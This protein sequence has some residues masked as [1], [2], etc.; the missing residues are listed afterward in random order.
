MQYGPVRFVVPLLQKSKSQKFLVGYFKGTI[1]IIIIDK[2]QDQPFLQL[3]LEA[4][5]ELTC[6]ACNPGGHNVCIGTTFG[7]MFIISLTSRNGNQADRKY[8]KI[9]RISNTTENAVTSIQMTTF[10]P[11]GSLLVAFDNGQ[12]RVWQSVLSEEQR[13]KIE[14]YYKARLQLQDD[15]GKK[16]TKKDLRKSRV[17]IDIAQVQGMKFDVIDKFDMFENPHN[18]EEVTEEQAA[19]YRELYGVSPQYLDLIACFRARNTWTARP[20]SSRAS[21]L[22]CMCVT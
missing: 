16:A 8:V 3:P 2:L 12:V 18:L 20:S 11:D 19:N 9:T 4:D 21:L 1:K 5:E 14:D 13:T 10:N 17:P 15:T 6:A 22:D 7:N